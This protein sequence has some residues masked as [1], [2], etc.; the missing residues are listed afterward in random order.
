MR[1]A[2]P[3]P[4][5]FA[6]PGR[7]GLSLFLALV[8]VATLS[9]MAAVTLRI[10]SDEV[11]ISTRDLDASQTLA[12]AES[13]I[14]HGAAALTVNP[15]FLGEIS[16]TVEVSLDPDLAF[17][18]RLSLYVVRSL[19]ETGDGVA[20]ALEA[21]GTFR[22]QSRTLRVALRSVSPVVFAGRPREVRA[23]P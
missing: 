6:R 2:A 17:E 3:A 23:A 7:R 10:S 16:G 8:V 5:C 15:R 13:G 19:D 11:E 12:V 4:P 22:G 14:G 18:D 1:I 21:T 20:D 9:L